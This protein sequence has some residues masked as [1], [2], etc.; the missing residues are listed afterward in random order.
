[1]TEKEFA[2]FLNRSRDL[3]LV[4]LRVMDVELKDQDQHLFLKT[5]LFTLA[6][7]SAM[8]LQQVS[9]EQKEET[10]NIFCGTVVESVQQLETAENSHYLA[11]QIIK[12]AMNK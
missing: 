8:I 1:M 2:D 4:L 3:C 6:K 7:T 11:K 10:L 12:K 5:T 9:D